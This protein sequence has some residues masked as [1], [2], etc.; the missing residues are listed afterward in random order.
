[1]DY[2]IQDSLCQPI[3]DTVN[4][5]SGVGVDFFSIPVGQGETMFGVG[6]KHFGDTN[7]Y[8]RSQMPAGWEFRMRSLY[9]EPLADAWPGSTLVGTAID[10]RIGTTN[11]LTI[12][13]ERARCSLMVTQDMADTTA[14][15]LYEL[16]A[17]APMA[18]P[19]LLGTMPGVSF[20]FDLEGRQPIIRQGELFFVR[21]MTPR[22]PG[23]GTNP[24]EGPIRI[25]LNGELRRPIY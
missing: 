8:L 20:G 19:M 11:F 1:M 10:F 5:V 21:F 2:E 18:I 4:V 13:Y 16:K 15:I 6:P 23:E 25:Y 9:V 3:Y 12:P 7:M 22:N 14:R 24:I 17:I